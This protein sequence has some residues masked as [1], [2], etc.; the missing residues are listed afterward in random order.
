[1]TDNAS[2]VKG[3]MELTRAIENGILICS[4]RVSNVIKD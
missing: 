4:N 3:W 1:M 2:S